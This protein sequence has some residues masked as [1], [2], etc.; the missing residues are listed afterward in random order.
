M[1]RN[2]K[3]KVSRITFITLADTQVL[4]KDQVPRSSFTMKY[5]ASKPEVAISGETPNGQGK[6]TGH[7]FNSPDSGKCRRRARISAG[8][9]A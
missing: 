9:P 1:K 8:G 3:N 4:R 6:T 2:E 7:I 5:L